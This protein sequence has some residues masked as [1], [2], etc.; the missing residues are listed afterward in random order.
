MKRA[1]IAASG[2]VQGVGFYHIRALAVR[3][4][5][6]GRVKNLDDG[7]V[8]IVC[9]GSQGDID[10]LLEGVRSMKPAGS[11]RRRERRVLGR[12]GLEN[13]K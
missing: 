3:L 12:R 9:E 7:M 10:A 8:E 5:P 13:S 1:E 2:L 6:T 11:A 4:H